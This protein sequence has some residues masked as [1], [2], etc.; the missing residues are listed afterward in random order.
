MIHLDTVC[1][2]HQPALSGGQ[3]WGVTGEP[4][5]LPV[6]GVQVC[7]RLIDHPDRIWQAH[8]FCTL[9]K[10]LVFRSLRTLGPL[11]QPPPVLV[12]RFSPNCSSGK[13]R[14]SAGVKGEAAEW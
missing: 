4:Y 3:W 2:R 9:L 7:R 5:S 6:C 10:W 11:P 13:G 12:L 14:L 8:A 1:L